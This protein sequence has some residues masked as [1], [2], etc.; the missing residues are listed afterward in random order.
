MEPNITQY[1]ILIA[2]TVSTILFWMMANLFFGLYLQYGYIDGAPS[3]GNI[4]Y[5]V[6]A[7]VTFI[8]LVRRLIKKWSKFGGSE[9]LKV[10]N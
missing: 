10:K 3:I 9:K 5:Y 6:I 7:I 2:N 1:F 4:I 8:W